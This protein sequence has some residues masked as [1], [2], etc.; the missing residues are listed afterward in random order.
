MGIGQQTA[1]PLTA[2]ERM[3]I[4]NARMYSATASAQGRLEAACS[5]GRSQRADLDWE[6]DRLRRAGAA[7]GSCGRATTSALAMMCGLPF[8]QRTP[9]PTLVAA[10][11]PSPAA[12]RR[13]AGLLHRHRGARRFAVRAARGHLRRRGRLHAGRFDVGRRRVARP[14]RCRYARTQ[15]HAALPRGGR[16]PDPRARRDRGAGRRH[17]STSARSTATTTTCCARTSPRSRQ[18][19]RIIASTGR[20]AD[21]AAGR[22][23]GDRR[24]HEL[25]RLR[26]RACTARAMAPELARRWRNAC[27]LQASPCPIPR[28]T[29]RPRRRRRFCHPPFEEL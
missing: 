2:V 11:L 3:P 29:T 27:C 16:Q 9:R 26:E 13:P 4:A 15:G 22:D 17:A 5:A 19:V 14:S 23:G 12:L 24:R 8:S 25:A 6:V 1:L 21:P 7:L 18:Q 20:D 28:T 10:P